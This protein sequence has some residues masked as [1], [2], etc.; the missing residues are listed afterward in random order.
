MSFGDAWLLSDPSQQTSRCP[1]GTVGLDVVLTR[2]FSRQVIWR[3]LSLVLNDP[4]ELVRRFGTFVALED[5][6]W[7]QIVGPF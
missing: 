6:V 1:E 3:G 5:R 4:S 7:P 2:L